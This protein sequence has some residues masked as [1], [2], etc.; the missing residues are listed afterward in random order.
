MV[1]SSLNVC[2]GNIVATKIRVLSELENSFI[3]NLDKSGN[4]V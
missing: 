2:I 4:I 1:S 3:E